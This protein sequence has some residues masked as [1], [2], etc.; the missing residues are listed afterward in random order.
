MLTV[1]IF[2]GIT[3]WPVVGLAQTG[4]STEIGGTTFH[5]FSNGRNCTSQHIGSQT[6]TNCH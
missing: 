5:N 2:L 3:I 4:S 6:F 1:L